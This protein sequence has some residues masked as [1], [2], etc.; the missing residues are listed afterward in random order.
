VPGRL[1]PG[2][3]S[4]WISSGFSRPGI[5]WSLVEPERQTLEQWVQATRRVAVVEQPV[6]SASGTIAAGRNGPRPAFFPRNPP[7]WG[8][9]GV[10]SRRH[11]LVVLARVPDDLVRRA[12]KSARAPWDIRKNV[13][14]GSEGRGDFVRGSAFDETPPGLQWPPL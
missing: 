4:A 11:C 13:H 7:A 10:A 14:R 9:Q 12:L 1:R 2:Q 5:S 3:P 8:G 6:S